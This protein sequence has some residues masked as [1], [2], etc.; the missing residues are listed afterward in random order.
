MATNSNEPALTPTN[1]NN[2]QHAPL[3]TNYTESAPIS[4]TTDFCDPNLYEKFL[5]F[6]QA[7]QSK[8]A[9]AN[10]VT[11]APDDDQTASYCDTKFLGPPYQQLIEFLDILKALQISTQ[12]HLEIHSSSSLQT[13]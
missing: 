10:V 12:N 7:Q 4:A 13:R 3:V 5:Q 8:T 6:V 9:S 11:I 1:S 2:N